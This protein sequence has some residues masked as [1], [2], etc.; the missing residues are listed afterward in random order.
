MSAPQLSPARR[1]VLERRAAAARRRALLAFSLLLATVV[2]GIIGATT[3][4][5][6]WFAVI[7]AALLASVLVLGRRAVLANQR[8]DVAWAQ[9]SAR[10]KYRPREMS[11]TERRLAG[12]P[13]PAVRTAQTGAQRE[14]VSTTVISRVES[15]LFAKK[16]VT[17]RPVSTPVA[18][19]GTPARSNLP[20][21]QSAPSARSAS[22]AHTA[23]R[24]VAKQHGSAQSPAQSGRSAGSAW[25]AVPVP[26]PVY[27]AK[28]AAPKWEAPG[29]TTHLQQVTKDRIA[30]IEREASLRDAPREVPDSAEVSQPS[31][32]DEHA[33]G[34]GSPDSLGVS[35]NAVLARRRAI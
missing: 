3:S 17:G 19:S 23:V 1:A 24:P 35:L 16:H 34:T 30:E 2:I 9:R 12:R 31:A 18:S 5:S 29:I 15:S 11:E 25:R 20:K 8:N 4:L 14:D 27:A 26:P 33:A 10:T 6:L 28:T 22:G 32:T 21:A 13:A 7:P